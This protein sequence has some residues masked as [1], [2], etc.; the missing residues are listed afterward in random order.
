[1]RK[2]YASFSVMLLLSLSSCSKESA[3]TE[4]PIVTPTDRVINFSGFDWVVRKTKTAKEGPG[5]NLFS[6][7]KNNV[8]VDEQG[9]L[10]LKITHQAGQWYC[11]G[12]ILKNTL[13]YG[14]YTFYINS[15]ISKLDENVV[16]G[17]FTHLT[18]TQ[19]IDIEFSK[20][21]VSDNINTQ[22]AVQPSDKAG[23]KVRFDIPSDLGPT[24]HSF[25][26]QKDKISFESLHHN[27]GT[28]HVL[29]KWDYTGSDI[30][31]DKEERLKMNL[32]LFRG[33]MPKNLKEQEIV[34]DSVKFEG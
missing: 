24:T 10:H 13:G 11:S 5:P 20:W 29:H 3:I 6:D 21:S 26:W 32:W 18:D 31:P 23:N 19:E 9:R 1:M 30:P 33:Q 27:Q 14:K 17:L 28:A 12:I 2:T 15:D 4:N 8:W 22:F 25:N 7:S 16:A 34:I